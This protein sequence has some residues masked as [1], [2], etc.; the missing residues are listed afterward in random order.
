M[1]TL[2]L[3]AVMAADP[4]PW[5]TNY[6]DP[7]LNRLVTQALAKNLDLQS[8]AQRIAESR[9]LT[10]ESRSKLLPAINLTPSAQRLRGGF[11]QGIARIPQSSGQVQSGSFVSPFETGLL[12][13]GL[14][15]KW[16]LDLFGSN[17]AG[18][19]AARADLQADEQRRDDLAITVSAEVARTYVQLRG[20]EERIAITRRTL[21]ALR[22]LLEL[23]D[24]RVKAG[25]ASQLDSERQRLLL[26]NT[27]ATL[28]PLE[29]DRERAL[30][31]LAVLVGDEAVGKSPLAATDATP[32]P[33]SAPV[34]KAEVPSELLK[35]RPDVREADAKLAAALARLKQ[36]KTDLYPKINLNGLVGRQG[37]SVSSLAFGGGNFFSLG[38]QLQLPIFSGGRI[39]A[40]IAA[41]Q[42]RVEQQRIAYRNELLVAFEEAANALTNLQ[43]QREREGKLAAAAQSARTSLDLSQDLQ[44][45]GL[46]DF[47]T[48]LDS[49]RSLLDAEFQQ[50]LARTQVLVESVALYKA[51][52]GGWPQ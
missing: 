29:A 48:V 51:L 47:L 22:Q 13:G 23:T 17:R 20:Y 11:S 7:E 9:A 32:T 21:D 44:Q 28:P 43:R 40:N 50:S 41:Q 8:A 36:S 25:L 38:P 52:A 3:L 24:D 19:A 26:V 10:G 2:F 27:E 4:T 34:V 39:K 45:A 30:Q 1:T 42:A 14:D 18:L 35:R 33:L 6:G 16:E 46:N 31:R 49:Q 37:T 12:Q 5:W 15:M